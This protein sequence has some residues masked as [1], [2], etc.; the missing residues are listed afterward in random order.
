MRISKRTRER[1]ALICAIAACDENDGIG[2]VA[3]TLGVPDGDSVRRLAL[4]AQAHA[5]RSMRRTAGRMWMGE[6]LPPD[7]RRRRMAKVNY[8]QTYAE[9]EA[10]LRTGWE[11]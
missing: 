3:N 6:R 8:G 9:A 10:L 7:S 4:E 11:P 5:F 1:A 2:S